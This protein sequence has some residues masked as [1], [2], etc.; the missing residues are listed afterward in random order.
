[1][2]VLQTFPKHSL[3]A[4]IIPKAAEVLCKEMSVQPLSLQS[5]SLRDAWALASCGN[6]RASGKHLFSLLQC[7]KALAAHVLREA[8]EIAKRQDGSPRE[9]AWSLSER[10][11][12]GR[13]PLG[14]LSPTRLIDESLPRV[15]QGLV[16]SLAEAPWQVAPGTSEVLMRIRFALGLVDHLRSLLEAQQRLAWSSLEPKALCMLQE[17]YG[18]LKGL[19]STPW[20]ATSGSAWDPDASRLKAKLRPLT[21]S[22]SAWGG[23]AP[24]LRHA[25]EFLTEQLVGSGVLGRAQDR[26]AAATVS[27]LAS[28]LIRREMGHEP[29]EEALAS[30]SFKQPSPEA[31]PKVVGE[32]TQEEN[33][34]RVQQLFLVLEAIHSLWP[35]ASCGLPNSATFAADISR[36]AV[37]VAKQLGRFEGSSSAVMILQWS[38]GGPAPESDLP[39]QIPGCGGLDHERLCLIQRRSLLA[40]RHHLLSSLGCWWSSSLAILANASYVESIQ[41]SATRKHQSSSSYI[42]LGKWLRMR[43]SL[44]EMWHTFSV[45]LDDAKAWSLNLC[46]MVASTSVQNFKL[47]RSLLQSLAGSCFDVTGARAGDAED[48]PACCHFLAVQ[49]HGL[50]LGAKERGDEVDA[51]LMS[52]VDVVM[53]V[54]QELA[55]KGERL[56]ELAEELEKLRA[57]LAVVGDQAMGQPGHYPSEDAEIHKKCLKSAGAWPMSLQEILKSFGL[58]ALQLL[59]QCCRNR[60]GMS[61]SDAVSA[62]GCLWA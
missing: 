32:E 45:M 58:P 43:E 6:D 35:L 3:I 36:Y 27:I 20:L 1:M 24:P 47:H 13:I 44:K 37:V 39:L 46:A 55:D 52:A 53:T 42:G 56:P 60:K 2:A 8:P 30:L 34:K 7:A 61:A 28:L 59:E 14:S 41:S 19:P 26:P 4:D 48:W 29:P 12:E 15:G 21:D 51:P 50:Q 38:I 17:I 5:C 57:G 22:I 40:M 49:L 18:F 25:S 9:S 62:C 23:L 54:G 33:T 11:Q 10:F 31:E 16:E